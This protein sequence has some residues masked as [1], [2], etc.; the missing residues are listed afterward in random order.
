MRKFLVGLLLLLV[1]YGILRDFLIL[2][3]ASAAMRAR[4][5]TC[6]TAQAALENAV[7]L[8]NLEA[9]TPEEMMNQLDA[10]SLLDR[11]FVPLLPICPFNGQ[12]RGT[13]ASN[14]MDVSCSFH[15]NLDQTIPGRI[16]PGYGLLYWLNDWFHTISKP[17]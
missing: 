13:L 17:R 7:E 1:G 5:K 10:R 15:G 16:D 3:Y 12:F 11:K 14:V 6:F 8:Y 4:Q 2:G 9:K